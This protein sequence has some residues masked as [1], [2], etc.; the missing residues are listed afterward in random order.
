MFVASMQTV[1]LFF[2]KANFH[3]FLLKNK[4]IIHPKFITMEFRS[5]PKFKFNV[6]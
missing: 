3:E 6:L 4:F 5:N 2:Y 1:V